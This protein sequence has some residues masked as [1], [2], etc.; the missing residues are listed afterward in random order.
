MWII[1]MPLLV[2][3]VVTI[4]IAVPEIPIMVTIPAMVML[5]AAA[6]PFPETVIELASLISRVDPTSTGIRSPSPVALMP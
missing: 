1:S 3:V 2:A 6:V 5:H 4:V